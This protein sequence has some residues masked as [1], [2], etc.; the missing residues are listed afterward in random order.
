M[1]D[2]AELVTVYYSLISMDHHKHK[3]T[4][5]TIETVFGPGE[6]VSYHAFHSGYHNEI[7]EYGD[8]PDRATYAE[9]AEDL[10]EALRGFIRKEVAFANR[11]LSETDRD[12]HDKAMASTV[13]LRVQEQNYDWI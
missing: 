3:D 8:G 7:G 6:P 4:Y 11:R 5:F 9:A 12:A 10:R 13:L 1:E 2:I